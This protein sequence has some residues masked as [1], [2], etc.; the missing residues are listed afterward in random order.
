MAEPAEIAERVV[1]RLAAGRQLAGRAVLVTAGGTREP[2]DAVRYVGNRSSGKMGV[3][4]ADEAAR[5]GADVTLVLA[6]AT[7]EPV[8]ADARS[9]APSPPPS[10]EQAT[11]AAAEA[12][13]VVV[14][15]A[16]VSDY[17]PADPDTG[18]R[19]KGG[20]PWH[21]TMRADHGY[22]PGAG[23]TPSDRAG[24]GRVCSR[25]RPRGESTAHAPSSSARRVDMIVMNDI[26]RSGHRI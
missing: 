5:R 15:S 24:A 7:A 10:C 16:A 21:V 4:V 18:K 23:A 9:C 3:A 8:R 19:T 2:L 22:P 25:A 6:A 17:R 1:A 14:M 20:E 26:S 11:L 12:A 13:D